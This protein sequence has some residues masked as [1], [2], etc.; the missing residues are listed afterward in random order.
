MIYIYDMYIYIYT[1][2]ICIYVCII[3]STIDPNI[4][5]KTQLS[6]T[7]SIALA[8]GAGERGATTNTDEDWRGLWH[9]PLQVLYQGQGWLGWPKLKNPAIDDID[10]SQILVSTMG[11]AGQILDKCPIHPFGL[12]CFPHEHRSLIGFCLPCLLTGGSL[13]CLESW[14]QDIR[15]T[16]G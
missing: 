2:D 5:S 16:H 7:S 14:R 12:K 4:G 3:P 15:E 6:N 10:G 13:S 8:P 11:N 9:W 1:Y